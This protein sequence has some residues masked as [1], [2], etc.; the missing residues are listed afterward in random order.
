MATTSLLRASKKKG[1][2]SKPDPQD[3]T[4]QGHPSPLSPHLW[5][6]LLLNALAGIQVLHQEDEGEQVSRADG[7]GIAAV[8]W[9]TEGSSRRANS[10]PGRVLEP[11]PVAPGVEGQQL[12]VHQEEG[13]S[14]L[15]ATALGAG[16]DVLH[17]LPLQE[18]D[19]LLTQ[20]RVDQPLHRL[21]CGLG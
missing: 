16:V 13:V 5:A 11:G 3:I 9:R 18:L 17:H 19:A 8:G 7:A 1:R 4:L 21:R 20:L 2:K 14:H 12:G 15:I 6:E 10:C